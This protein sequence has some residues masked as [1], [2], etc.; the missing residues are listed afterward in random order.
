MALN[1][2]KVVSVILAILKTAKDN[3]TLMEE[4]K[5]RGISLEQLL[6]AAIAAAIVAELGNRAR[7]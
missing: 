7:S 5:R 1:R 4:T 6:A 2:N 3:A